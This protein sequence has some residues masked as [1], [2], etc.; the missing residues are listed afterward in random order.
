MASNSLQFFLRSSLTMGSL[1]G[2]AA[3]VHYALK[4]DLV[5]YAMCPQLRSALTSAD[6]SLP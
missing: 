5:R 3:I 1:F 4:P 6:L 2:G